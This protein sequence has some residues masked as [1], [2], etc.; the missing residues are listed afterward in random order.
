MLD[1]ERIDDWDSDLFEVGPVAC[2]EGQAV[3]ERR[4]QQ[5]QTR[6]FPDAESRA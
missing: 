2:R 4:V 6:L 1:V 5:P 3:D